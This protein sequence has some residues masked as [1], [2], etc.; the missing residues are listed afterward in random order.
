MAIGQPDTRC[1]F[2]SCPT[3]I[4]VIAMQNINGTTQDKRQAN[5]C[6]PRTKL[7]T[8]TTSSGGAHRRF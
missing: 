7:P 5:G 6:E 2:P 8:S 3:A 1:N 4:L